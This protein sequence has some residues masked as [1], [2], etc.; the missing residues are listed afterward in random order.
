MGYGSFSFLYSDFQPEFRG[1]QG[2]RER[3]P[4]VLQLASKNE[5]ACEIRPDSV[6][7]TQRWILCSKLCFRASI[8]ASIYTVL[9]QPSTLRGMV[10]WVVTHLHGLRKVGTLVQLTGVA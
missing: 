6:V 2:F 3:L 4:R 7:E 1:T 10:K 5:L 9:T 8:S